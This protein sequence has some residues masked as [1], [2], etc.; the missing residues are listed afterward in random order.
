MITEGT[1]LIRAVTP[2][3]RTIMVMGSCK[4]PLPGRMIC[5]GTR[6]W[7]KPSSSAAWA[8]ALMAPMSFS[9]S[10]TGREMPICMS[11]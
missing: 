1:S 9:S 6:K 8:K 3:I 10:R 11:K 2:A 7:L 4:G 5:S